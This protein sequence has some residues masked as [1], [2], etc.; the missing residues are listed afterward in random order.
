MMPPTADRLELPALAQDPSIERALVELRTKL[1]AWSAA[2]ERAQ[3]RLDRCA[4]G[5][6]LEKASAVLSQPLPFPAPAPGNEAGASADQ[7]AA[8]DSP[9][10]C[11]KR[12][13]REPE[14]E[15]A[16]ADAPAIRTPRIS[17]AASRDVEPRPSEAPGDS[18]AKSESGHKKVVLKKG[19]G[20]SPGPAA[21]ARPAGPPQ[22]PEDEAL[23]AQLPPEVA[24]AIRVKRRLTGNRRS[25]AD[26]VREYQ[27][28]GGNARSGDG[29]SWSWWSRG[30]K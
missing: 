25:V 9:P 21:P 28:S 14:P 10:T 8:E 27:E 29:A 6:E 4:A 12:A 16:P 5:I 24:A 13:A 22:S 26:L 1:A 2:M 30:K 15:L 7:P 19:R 17:S 23:L 18:D 3:A 20:I 11:L